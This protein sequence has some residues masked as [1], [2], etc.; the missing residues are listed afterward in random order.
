[1]HF[2]DERLPRMDCEKT[3]PLM[4]RLR[5]TDKLRRR[6]SLQGLGPI[7]PFTHKQTRPIWFREYLF[8][9][10]TF[11]NVKAILKS[12]AHVIKSRRG[13]KSRA[14]V[15]STSAPR[16]D[17][18]HTDVQTNRGELDTDYLITDTSLPARGYSRP[19]NRLDRVAFHE[20][21]YL[22]PPRWPTAG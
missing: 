18:K 7:A 4:L 5:R 10:P 19:T 21:F 6:P 17:N 12:Y 20:L 2:R 8:C 9:V 13:T 15:L 11:E 16:G 14:R 22:S 1:M 3:A